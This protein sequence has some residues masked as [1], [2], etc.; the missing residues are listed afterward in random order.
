M[1]SRC[2]A[3]VFRRGAL[4]QQPAILRHVAIVLG[5][6]AAEEMAPF[7]VGD[8]VQIISLRGTDRRPQRDFPWVGYRPRRQSRNADGYCTANWCPNRYA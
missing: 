7:V 5:E 6:S 3:G 8:E 4:F 2:R 1:F